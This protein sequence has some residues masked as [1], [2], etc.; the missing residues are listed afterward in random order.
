M[1]NVSSLTWTD[2]TGTDYCVCPACRSDACYY[3]NDEDG[4]GW[5]CWTCGRDETGKINRDYEHDCPAC[6]WHVLKRDPDARHQWHCPRCYADFSGDRDTGPQGEPVYPNPCPTCGEKAVYGYLRDNGPKPAYYRCEACETEF[7]A[8]HTGHLIPPEPCEACGRVTVQLFEHL[9]F[10]RGQRIVNEIKRCGHCGQ[11][12]DLEL[13][14]LHKD[15]TP[16]VRKQAED[17]GKH[18]TIKIAEEHTP[19][20]KQE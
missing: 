12:Y 16:I 15:L 2:D 7:F 6:G 8:T 14:P 5:R 3:Y 19:A 18:I 4:E 11:L 17:K 10:P 13:H 1:I 20:A 9:Q